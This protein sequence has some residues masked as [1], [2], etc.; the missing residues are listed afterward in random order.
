MIVADPVETLVLGPQCAGMRMTPEEFDAIDEYDEFYRYQLID[1]VVIVSPLPGP[2]YWSPNDL[3][4]HLLL[5]Y[6]ERHPQGAAMDA[7]SP[8]QYIPVGSSRR[9][10]DRV[11]WTGRGRLPNRKRD[12]PTIAIEFVSYG[13]A[14]W[15]RDYE[16]KRDEYLSVGVI[17]YW[18]IDRFA[19][20]L[21]VFSK[22]ASGVKESVV[23]ENESYQ[24]PLLPGFKLP[25]AQLFELADKWI[26]AEQSE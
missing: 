15:R 18:I 3:L 13:Q 17:E 19:R 1:G 26:A 8:E 25:L 4:G 7:T 10:A 12:L 24:T 14:A 21:T 6:R 16:Q 20:R 11:I 23:G 5:D 22:T 9:L 2:E